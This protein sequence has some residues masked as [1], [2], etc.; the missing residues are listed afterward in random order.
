MAFIVGL[1]LAF[2]VG[3]HIPEA[4]LGDRFVFT[5]YL[6]A[7]DHWWLEHLR[8]SSKP[9]TWLVSL[10]RDDVGCTGAASW[11]CPTSRRAGSARRMSVSIPA[12]LVAGFHR[13]RGGV[14]PAA[15]VLS[16]LRR[17]VKGRAN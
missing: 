7:D 16:L 12:A 1:H 9:G 10:V 5:L 13:R 6:T 14:V 3:L 11:H 15:Y 17:A 4:V 8:G 2:T